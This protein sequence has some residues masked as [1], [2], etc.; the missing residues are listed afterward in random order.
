MK[1]KW[2]QTT[3]RTLLATLGLAVLLGTPALTQ[4]DQGKWWT[5][6]Q[7]SRTPVAHRPSND[8]ARPGPS[9]GP[10]QSQRGGYAYSRPW[11]GGP[12]RRDV[13]M[14]RRGPRGHFFRARRVF[15]E[16]YYNRHIVYV[17]PVRFYFCAD[18]RVG[19]LNI[20]VDPYRY[21]DFLYGCNFCDARFDTYDGYSAHLSHCDARPDGYDVRARDW[22]DDDYLDD[23]RD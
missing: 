13:I 7:G 6:K 9:Y 8:W 2:Q 20:H 15:V 22:E 1:T 21:D 12:A 17:R 11:L 3:R 18:A 16:P 5:P 14:I 19:P 4:A 10:R 23:G